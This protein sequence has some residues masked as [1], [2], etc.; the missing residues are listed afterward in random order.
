MPEKL[1]NRETFMA[2]SG[3]RLYTPDQVADLIEYSINRERE[4]ALDAV[5][6]DILN[7]CISHC[8]NRWLCRTQIDAAI[9]KEKNGG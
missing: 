1:F 7:N 4:R 5:G 6:A 3:G 2:L 9:E 8:P